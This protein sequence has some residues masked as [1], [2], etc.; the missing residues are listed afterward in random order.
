MEL[1]FPIV[2]VSMTLSHWTTIWNLKKKGN[3]CCLEVCVQMRYLLC[4]LTR[5]CCQYAHSTCVHV[6]H[7]EICVW[8]WETG[9]V[10]YDSAPKATSMWSQ[11]HCQNLLS[12]CQ[13]ELSGLLCWLLFPSAAW[14]SWWI[15]KNSWICWEF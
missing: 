1:Q 5:T 8:L 13:L 9:L 3:N 6:I 15:S 7:L 11:M 14:R 12:V 10:S 4:F 2:T